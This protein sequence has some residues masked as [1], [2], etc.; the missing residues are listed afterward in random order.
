MSSTTWPS[1]TWPSTIWPSTTWPS[2]T[3]AVS[4]I[5]ALALGACG[6]ESGASAGTGPGNTTDLGQIVDNDAEKQDI[7]P[8]L[9]SAR[10]PA[11]DTTTAPDDGGATPVADSVA[12]VVDGGQTT[13]ADAGQADT[14]PPPTDAGAKPKDGGPIGPPTTWYQTCGAPVCQGGAWQPTPGVPECIEGEKVGDPCTTPAAM[15]DNKAGCKAFLVC[16]NKDPKQQPGGCPISRRAFKTDIRYLTRADEARYAEELAA[17]PLTTWAYREG[18]GRSH[19]GF[20]LEDA[21]GS[22][23][24]EAARDRVDLYSYISM[25]VAAIKVQQREIARLRAEVQL[26]RLGDSAPL[27]R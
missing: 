20:I 5:L 27:C 16:A 23:A 7:A 13:P 9:D 1:T 8:A 11:A 22:V 12:P 3:W 26:L 17:M 21:P 25:A 24:V 15:C 19:L 6:N 2:T 10:Q 4:G 18:D 14:A